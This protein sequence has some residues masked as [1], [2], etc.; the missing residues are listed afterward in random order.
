MPTST[1]TARARP[2]AQVLVEASAVA[3]GERRGL[4]LVVRPE[5]SRT[6]ARASQI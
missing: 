4:R 2:H 6:R 3:A 1:L 5:I